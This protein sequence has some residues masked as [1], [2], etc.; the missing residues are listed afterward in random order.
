MNRV[1]EERAQ[2]LGL[3]SGPREV[4]AALPFWHTST[5]WEQDAGEPVCPELLCLGWQAG[6]PRTCPHTAAPRPHAKPTPEAGQESQSRGLPTTHVLPKL[7]RLLCL[8]GKPGRIQALG[9][10]PTPG[11]DWPLTLHSVPLRLLLTG[12][13]GPSQRSIRLPPR[14]SPRRLSRALVGCSTLPIL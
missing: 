4:F 13:Q 8:R 9:R 1:L 2:S 6:S 3:A 11:K 14:P 5:L 12:S 7:T 10:R